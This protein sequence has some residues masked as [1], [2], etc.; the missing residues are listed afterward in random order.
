MLI[1]KPVWDNS[2]VHRPKNAGRKKEVKYIHGAIQKFAY[3]EAHDLIAYGGV[4]GKIFV[5]DQATKYERGVCDTFTPEVLALE[6]YDKQHYLISV[7]K[8][9]AV[10]LW[11]AQKLTQIQVVR[12]VQ[13]AMTQKA[14]T[15][16]VFYGRTGTVLLA[17]NKVFHYAL[18][19]DKECIVHHKQQMAVALD[20]SRAMKAKVQN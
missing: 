1:N 20:Y 2:I 5:M 13:H 12:Q 8:I 18:Q 9:G 7:S 3:S 4:Q 19:P 10:Q 11:D 16:A 15:N 6:F 17:T 14:L